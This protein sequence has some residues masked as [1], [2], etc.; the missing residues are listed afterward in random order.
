[1]VKYSHFAFKTVVA[2]QLNSIA[3]F[4]HRLRN[5]QRVVKK[6]GN[7]QG[8]PTIPRTRKWIR[9]ILRELGPGYFRR[10]FRMSYLTFRIFY[11]RIKADLRRVMKDTDRKNCPNGRIPLTSRVGIAI[12]Y[13]AGGCPYDIS[14]VFG[15]SHSDVLKSVDFVIDAM[16]ASPLFKIEFPSD[17]DKQRE[18]AAGFKALSEAHFDCCV[19]DVDGIL[20]WTHQPTEEDCEEI[21][22]GASKCYCARKGKF[23]LNM[24]AICDHQ[25]RFLDISILYGGSSSDVVAFEA[26]SIRSIL[27]QPG[28]LAEGL[29]LFGDNAYVN[30]P[31]MATPFPNVSGFTKQKDAYNFYHSQVRIRIECAFGIL[32]QRF[33]FLRQKAPQHFSMKKIIA[34]V[35]CLCKIHN[36]LIDMNP[37]NAR[38]VPSSSEED[39]FNMAINGGVP[40]EQREGSNFRVPS[41]LMGAGE[42]FDD[43]PDRSVRRRRVSRRYN[44][45][46]LPRDNMLIHVNDLGLQRPIRSSLTL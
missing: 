19:G 14:L 26:S 25:Y 46:L 16:N 35:S 17:H 23:G 21:E 18:I 7:R 10:A 34:T 30:R 9:Q 36:F 28:F 5:S 29:C 3:I 42:H 4:K 40:I 43:D 8:C 20:I 12:R 22:V 11:H 38:D 2:K 13:F 6:P 1:M 33:G 39:E 27:E 32:C 31:C 44:E 24:Q 41:Q 37:I 15:V 45:G